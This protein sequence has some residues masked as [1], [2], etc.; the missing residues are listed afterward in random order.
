MKR[1]VGCNILDHTVSRR[2][3]V[4]GATTAAGFGGFL[5]AT[6][7]KDV[8]GNHKQILQV[9]LQGGVSQLESW[10]PKPGTEL[11][12]PFLSIPT[13]VP[14]THISELLPHTAKMMHLLSLVRSINLKADDHSQCRLFMEKGR[15]TPFVGAVARNTGVY[16]F[17][18]AVAA[19]Y[20]DSRDTSLPGYIHISTRGIIDDT[21]GFLEPQYAQFKLEGV[22]APENLDLPNNISKKLYRAR[23]DFRTQL[24][25]QFAARRRKSYIDALG[26]SFNQ[27]SKLME[28]KGLFEAEQDPQDLE[29]YGTHDFARNCILGRTLLERG[30]T[31]VKVTHHGYDSHAEN[32]NFHLEQLGEFDKTFATLLGDLEDR[33]MLEHTLVMVYSEFGRTPKINHRYGR[34]HWGSAWSIALGGCGIQTGGIVGKTNDKGTEV[35]DREVHGGHLFHTY[36]KAVGIDPAQNH[37]VKGRAIPIG[38][39]AVEPVE[40]LLA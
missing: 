7:A 40:E 11:G 6:W 29:R 5:P 30:A 10:D 26:S 12:G 28:R 25:Q 34:D 16:P 13:S 36:L 27:A 14:G 24:D 19:K 39:P 2:N 4:L 33:G 37:D 22:K 15:N 32:F 8:A 17:L 35:T 23:N 38:D 1:N 21:A 9:Y 20:L 31:C 3:F 18:G